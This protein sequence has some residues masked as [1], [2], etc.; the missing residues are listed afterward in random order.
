MELA[1]HLAMLFYYFLI[2]KDLK[3]TEIIYSVFFSLLFLVS[4]IY[5]SLIKQKHPLV[6]KDIALVKD[7]LYIS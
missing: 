6:K 5:F 1:S 3:N 4:G 7:F 2:K